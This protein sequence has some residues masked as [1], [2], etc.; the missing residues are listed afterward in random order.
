GEVAV[1]GAG[2]AFVS[3]GTGASFGGK[4]RLLAT[5]GG[6]VS[7]AGPSLELPGDW[8]RNVTIFM[9]SGA[10]SEVDASNLQSLTVPGANWGRYDY[11]VVATNQGLVNLSGLAV[12]VGARQNDYGNDDWLTF[13]VDDAGELKLDSLQRVSRRTRFLLGESMA[14][15]AL[16]VVE[17]GRFELEEGVSLALPGLSRMEGGQ[18]VVPLGAEITASNVVAI[19][20]TTIDL[21]GRGSL[22]APSLT[23][24]S[25]SALDL[26]AG[27]TFVH[28]SLQQVDG[29]SLSVGE[30]VSIDL[31]AVSYDLPNDW[32]GH[33][34]L[35]AADGAGAQVTAEE[36][37]SLTAQGGNSGAW[38]YA[39][40]ARNGG[41][42]DLSGLRS[43]TGPRTDTFGNDDWLTF[44]IQSGGQLDLSGLEHV[45]RRARFQVEEP[46]A[47]PTLLNVSGGARFNV[48]GGAALDLAHLQSVDGATFQVDFAGSVEAP[49]LTS[50]QNMTLDVAVGGRFY[51]PALAD[52]S[53]ISADL[54]PGR[55]ITFGAVSELSRASLRVSGPAPLTVTA[56]NYTLPRW[57]ASRTLFEADGVGAVL[58]LSSLQGLSVEGGDW[59]GRDYAIQAQNGGRIDLSG[60]AAVVGAR[61]DAYGGDDW[62]SFYLETGGELTL[63]S[64]ETISRRTRFILHESLTL[65]ALTAV[66]WG[67][68]ELAE[69]VALNMPA[70]ERVEGGQLVIPSTASINAPTAEA[71]RNTTLDLTPGGRLIAPNVSDLSGSALTLESGEDVQLG[72]ITKFDQASLT[73]GSG[74]EIR[75]DAESYVVPEDYRAN[76]V[77]L[78][79]D[80]VGAR[81]F[82]PSLS[83]IE[84]PGA[85]GAHDYAVVARSGGE[86]DLPALGTLIGCR[87]DTY[88]ADD[89]LTLRAELGGVMRAGD[90]DLQRRARVVASGANTLMAARSLAVQAPALVQIA[91]PAVL[92]LEGDFSFNNTAE[93][94]IDLD[95][96]TLRFVGSGAHRLEAGGT[97]GGP[98]G[99]SSG[100]F[101]IGRLEIGEPGRPADVLAVDLVD[102]GHRGEGGAP[103]ALYL[104]G[105]LAGEGIALAPGS[106]LIVG[107]IPVY[108]RVGGNMVLLNDLLGGAEAVAFG[109]GLLARRGG[110]AVVAMTPSGSVLPVLDH[111]DLDFNMALD[112]AGF[113]TDDVEITGPSGDVP[114]LSVSQ[115]DADTWRVQFPGQ[116]AHGVYRIRV[117]PDVPDL[118]G[119]LPQMDQD[120][121][122]TAGTAADVFEGEVL[123]DTQG[124]L[125]LMATAFNGSA[126]IGVR[127]DE[128]LDTN[129]AAA[130]ERYEIAGIHPTNVL[131]RADGKTVELRMPEAPIV[132][133]TLHTSGLKDL[134]GNEQAGVESVDAD[135]FPL[136][137]IT[138]GSPTPPV[139]AFTADNRR[140][141]FYDGGGDIWSGSDRFRFYQ[142]PREGDFDVRMRVEELQSNS[143]YARVGVMAREKPTANSRHISV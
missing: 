127:F 100:N 106:R 90:L 142:E 85:W 92:E 132:P 114:A 7:V 38:D 2:S 11:S 95:D 10:G 32:R 136:T 4:A 20:S 87:A 109:E 94:Q 14:M 12:A 9:A 30:G 25:R 42:L 76:R 81:V 71:I 126:W 96:A 107:E 99:F 75:V 49:A 36:L 133:Y 80:G 43:V 73:A 66:E 63:D 129:I 124:P 101:G 18:L 62:L 105:S 37:E 40:A 122:G 68:F 35:L 21:S 45:S 98:N 141:E 47:L 16:D 103:E 135:V 60:L 67:R 54:G 140:F 93:E 39:V 29:L 51:A 23:D 61:F 31:D 53:G 130:P 64:L 22:I 108:A 70:L 41:A 134:L 102:N 15:P 119:L 143:H 26:Q 111:V 116:S 89:W 84:T 128:A 125:P 27:E 57:N 69:G 74:A 139:E 120:G 48:A 112:P 110:A 3:E 72:T 118:T 97:D 17:W 117:G 59:A 8:R 1:D 52:I 65:P 28:G 79:A 44:Y 121:D 58:D 123:V 131:V 78:S 24:L 77:I 138:L 46:L 137:G 113:T 6:R 33:R 115:V 56:T 34:T 82:A 91:G 5:G 55:D 83:R 13:R 104:Y 88:S 19:R 86:A 50:A